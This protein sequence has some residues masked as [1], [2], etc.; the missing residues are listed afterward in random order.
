MT[1]QIVIDDLTF[2][3]LH[4]ASSGPRR[5]RKFEFNRREHSPVSN[6]ARSDVLATQVVASSSSSTNQKSGVRKSVQSSAGSTVSETPV[7]A[8]DSDF[9]DD[10]K[11]KSIEVIPGR[12]YFSAEDLT[13]SA[14]SNGDDSTVEFV[15]LSREDLLN[16]TWSNTPYFGPLS[17]TQLLLW[18]DHFVSLQRSLKDEDDT[19]AI[20]FFI[21]QPLEMALNSEFQHPRRRNEILTNGILLMT[22]SLV[23]FLNWNIEDAIAM[24]STKFPYLSPFI[25]VHGYPIGVSVRDCLMGLK[26][27]MK[28]DLLDINAFDIQR[29][30]EVRSKLDL[31][32]IIEGKLAASCSP[33]YLSINGYIPALDDFADFFADN[34]ISGIVRLNDP[35]YPSSFFTQ[36]TIEHCDLPFSD[37]C[38]PSAD[39][40]SSFLEFVD[41]HVDSGMAVV[42]HCRGG[43][44]R[45]G[46]LIACYLMRSFKFTALEAIG[47]LRLRRPGSVSSM[48]QQFLMEMEE[49]IWKLAEG[50]SAQLSPYHENVRLCNLE[51]VLKVNLMNSTNN[52]LFFRLHSLTFRRRSG[53]KPTWKIRTL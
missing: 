21:E 46:T 35:L 11:E 41:R 10:W 13:M 18:K 51:T 15:S 48:Q 24:F 34:G 7:C 38:I 29:E 27:A 2:G 45:T 50:P 31:N 20:C 4:D 1:S 43:I 39:L 8:E 42:V 9:I 40:V 28:H 36:K 52:L 44:G 49:Q 17:L 19:S 12:L 16:L 33:G 26:K 30:I 3:G 37:G 22:A 5:H 53:W 23:L 47:F 6:L 14:H 32:W 25:S